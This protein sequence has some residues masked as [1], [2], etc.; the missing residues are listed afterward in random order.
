MSRLFA[1][2]AGINRYHPQS[3][4]NV[5]H[6][7]G[8]RN[9]ILGLQTL[10]E[11]RFPADRRALV[12]LLD[13]DA[14]YQNVI[15]HFGKKLLLQAGP[16]DVVLFAYA[17]HGSR[18]DAAPEF[19]KYYPEGKE[20]T[21]VLYDSRIPG[22]LDLADKELAVLIERVAATGAHVAVLL[23]SCHSGSATRSLGDFTLGSVRQTSS[24]TG[25]RPLDSY[26]NG[27]YLK[28]SDFYLPNSRHIALAACDRTEKAFELTSQRGLFS[29]KLL[30][31]LE[32][33]GGQI[34]YADLY[35][36]CRLGMAQITNQQRP[37]FDTY[38]YFNAYDSFLRQGAA[39]AGSPLRIYFTDNTWQATMGAVHGLPVASGN[40]ATFEVLKNG[41]VL[42]QVR[43][44]VVGMESSSLEQPGF[45]LTANETYEA[46]L[47]SLPAPRTVFLLKGDP[48]QVEETQRALQAFRPLHFALS[49]DAAQATCR[50]EVDSDRI[51]IF[52]SADNAR[53][54]TIEGTDR[55]KMFADAFEKL[56]LI[57]RWEK[58]LELDNKETRINHNDVELILVELDQAGT[59]LRKTADREIVIDILRVNNEEQKVP[60]RLEIRNK[61]AA[62]A[63]Y[64]ALFYADDSYGFQAAGYNEQIPA[65]SA[66]IAMDKNAA[67]VQYAFELSGKPETMDIFKL[68]VSNS[69]ISGEGL[70]QNGFTLGE[71]VDYWVTRSGTRGDTVSQARAIFGMSAPTQQ[72]DVNDW[73]A[74]TLRVRSVA[75]QAGVGDQAVSL[76]DDFIRIL[77]HP[78]FRSGVALSAANAAGRSIE[79]M[80]VIADLAQNSG[81][82][83]LA[84]GAPSRDVA[85]PN[86]LELTDIQN[87]AALA[88]QPLQIEIAAQLQ[89]KDDYEDLL[90]PLTFDG[91]H[92]LPLGE[93]QRLAN[94]N[95]LVSIA[96]LP[97]APD[98][99]RRSLGKALKMCFLKLVLRKEDVQQL[100][101]ADYSR[102]TAERRPDNLP[103]K[104]AAAKNILLV[105]HG[106]IGDSKCMAECM[107]RAYNEKLFDLVLTF[108]YENLNTKIEVTAARLAD[109]LAAAGI[110]PASGKKIT[111]LAHSMGGLVARYFIENLQGNKVVS[112]LIMAGTPNGGSAIAKATAYRD[113]LMPLLTLAI[114][115]AWGIPA[116]GVLLAILKHSKMVTPTL[117]QMYI[118]HPDGFLKNL[119][120]TADPGVRY[121]IVAGNLHD[122]LNQNAGQKALM[123]K[124]LGLGGKLFYGNEPNDLAVSIESIKAVPATRTPAP[125]AA[126][127]AGNH[128]NYF[129]EEGCVEAIMGYVKKSNLKTSI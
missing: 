107:R 98:E 51:Q 84:F 92:L 44:R 11:T 118:D 20:E 48:T 10:L 52:R 108:D 50:I 86:M 13:H 87:E 68:F 4:A 41:E 59:V 23:D 69:K 91:Q 124:L 7:H 24:R 22:G 46:R 47:T 70:Q 65:Q 122:F 38:G 93:V 30:Q 102:E 89:E 1:L 66:A 114:N 101:W 110:T 117:E 125:E 96:H 64:C 115:S 55:N 54:R 58:T 8:C 71:T 120:K 105:T 103:E 112:Q 85:A 61:N 40:P 2:L 56:E 83:L 100:C 19:L 57:A 12:T 18:E 9:D 75:R 34:S 78:A 21:L 88:D 109:K 77:P 6:L 49:A 42:G 129:E 119:A 3:D 33:T 79:P 82:G 36:Q 73:Y 37:Q 74:I 16:G 45:T 80:S 99:H 113:F 67:G 62:K 127:V 60:F 104:V 14:T 31:V 53:L 81:A 29:T 72:E 106:I 32:K 26:L 126:V 28:R 25:P 43:S 116:A 95:A 5:S 63:R 27:E 90:L 121:S 17:G 35:T 39:S 76:A 128:L 94:G 111:I 97:A 123:D 15:D